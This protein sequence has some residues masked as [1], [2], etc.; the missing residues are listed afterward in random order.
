MSDFNPQR[1][2]L[3]RMRRGVSRWNMAVSVGLKRREY[4]NVMEGN[5]TPDEIT[6]MKWS[7]LLD[8]P[9]TF[10]YGDDIDIPSAESFSH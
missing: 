1:L 6:L 7:G 9:V 2:E 4:N 8:F 10:F 5:L 3:A